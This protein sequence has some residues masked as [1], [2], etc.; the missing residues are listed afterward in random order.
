M[1]VPSAV[2]PMVLVGREHWTRTLPVWPLLESLASG[3]TMEPRVHL[4]DDVR[5]V[6]AILEAH[7][8]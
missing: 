3:R 1:E 7:H 4:V 6:A 5:E 2:A 8:R